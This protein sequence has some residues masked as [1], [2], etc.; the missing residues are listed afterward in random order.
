M[1]QSITTQSAAAN[2]EREREA[3]SADKV[4]QDIIAAADLPGR[5]KKA[6]I[7]PMSIIGGDKLMAF[8]LLRTMGVID[9]RREKKGMAFMPP[10][11]FAGPEARAKASEGHLSHFRRRP[12]NI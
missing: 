3:D 7:P 10:V 1:E 8:R 4:F 2:E 12:N 5:Q 6:L 9:R 11:R